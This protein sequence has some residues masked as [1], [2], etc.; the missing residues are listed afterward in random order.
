[1]KDYNEYTSSR[2]NFNFSYNTLEIKEIFENASKLESYSDDGFIRAISNEFIIW[3]NYF[4]KD[5]WYKYDDI[6]RSNKLH[7]LLPN[8]DIFFLKSYESLTDDY[9]K[10]NKY[11]LYGQT[12]LHNIYV[13]VG[14]KIN[15]MI[16]STVWDVPYK[17]NTFT[18]NDMNFIHESLIQEYDVGQSYLATVYRTTSG[19]ISLPRIEGVKIDYESDF[20]FRLQ[21][22]FG[23]VLL[24]ERSYNNGNY[25]YLPFYEKN[26][27]TK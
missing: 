9:K 6:I 7:E 8:D 3:S 4:I 5:G 20:M 12:I 15:Q 11:Q 18:E 16:E 10:E 24:R 19:V 22:Y 25:L 27:N 1:M 17:L 26:K 2:L 21:S 13:Y 23:G 14:Q